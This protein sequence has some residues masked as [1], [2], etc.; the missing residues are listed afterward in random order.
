MTPFAGLPPD[1]SRHVLSGVAGPAP[2]RQALW[3]VHPSRR[4]ETYVGPE[5]VNVSAGLARWPSVP[6]IDLTGWAPAVP[7]GLSC[8]GG[9]WGD[10]AL[11]RTRLVPL[12]TTPLSVRARFS[13]WIAPRRRCSE[14]PSSPDIEGASF[15]RAL[16]H[17]ASGSDPT[18][19]RTPASFR[20]ARGCRGLRSRAH[21]SVP[22]S[23]AGAHRARAVF[24]GDR[25]GGTR[26]SMARSHRLGRPSFMHNGRGTQHFTEHF[27]W[28]PWCGSLGSCVT[29]RGPPVIGPRSVVAVLG[30]GGRLVS[31]RGWSC[32]SVWPPPLP[33]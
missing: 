22:R 2:G 19:W 21:L 9:A 5:P 23:P 32:Q 7:R 6:A 8:R 27:Q 13:G 29:L 17:V 16:A 24:T 11:R 15:T 28:W 30:S 10:P 4:T 26:G 14:G 20:G 33:I 25:P 1:P 3:P 12:I 18:P 31:L